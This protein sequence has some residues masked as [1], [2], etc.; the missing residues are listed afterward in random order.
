MEILDAIGDPGNSEWTILQPVDGHDREMLPQELSALR[1]LCPDNAFAVIPVR[2][3]WFRELSPWA[4]PAVFRGQED[5]GNGASAT[6]EALLREAV[7]RAGGKKIL[8]GYSLA[9][10]FALWAGYRTDVFDAIVAASPS[11]WYPGWEEYMARNRCRAPRV[12]L[13]LGTQEEHARHPLL[14]TAG[15]RI[16]QQYEILKRQEVRTVLEWNPGNHFREADRRTAAGF[17]W[18]MRRA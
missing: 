14:R 6:L 16:R 11:V 17:A 10:L 13:S 7:P 18:V 9:G 5:F 1:E 8:G 3:D 4:A 12:Y 2:V 15:D